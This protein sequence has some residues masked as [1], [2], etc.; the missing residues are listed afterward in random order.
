MSSYITRRA[1]AELLKLAFSTFIDSIVDTLPPTNPNPHLSTADMPYNPGNPPYYLAAQHPLPPSPQ[2]LSPVEPN[3]GIDSNHPDHPFF[4]YSTA[5][6]EVDEL[7]L[8]DLLNIEPPSFAGDVF[9]QKVDTLI[10]PT[11]EEFEALADKYNRNQPLPPSRFAK[12]N[13]HLSTLLIMFTAILYGIIF[14]I[15]METLGVTYV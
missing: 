2:P 11:D 3:V 15:L 4:W 6:L 1:Q 5:P 10:H 12:E 7:N 9:I 8:T 14:F 13:V